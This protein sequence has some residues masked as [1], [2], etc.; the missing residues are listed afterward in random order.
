MSLLPSPN[1]SEL[2]SEVIAMFSHL[3][4]IVGF[5]RSVAEIYGIK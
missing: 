1:L 4:R 3:T 5:P 2:E